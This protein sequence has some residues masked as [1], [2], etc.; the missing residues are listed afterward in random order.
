MMARSYA[1]GF[2]IYDGAHRFSMVDGGAMNSINIL[3]RP[4]ALLRVTEDVDDIYIIAQLAVLT[5]A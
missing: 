3:P 5:K 4:S 1:L 2:Y